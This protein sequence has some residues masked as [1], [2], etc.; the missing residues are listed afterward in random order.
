[1]GGS[2]GSV[3]S[4]HST[5]VTILCDL[6]PGKGSLAS[7]APAAVPHTDGPDR[8]DAADPRARRAPA[9]GRPNI[10]QLRGYEV[11]A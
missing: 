7:E 6:R 8:R 5:V 1:M 3:V 4:N 9:R 2:A 10:M 11:A